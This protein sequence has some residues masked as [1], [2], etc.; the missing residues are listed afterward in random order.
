[1]GLALNEQMPEVIC[2]DDVVRE[3]FLHLL[4]AKVVEPDCAELLGFLI[5]DVSSIS[6]N[7]S[8]RQGLKPL[9]F[10]VVD[11]STSL[12]TILYCSFT[13]HWP[14]LSFYTSLDPHQLSSLK[15]SKG[16]MRC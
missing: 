14:F 7:W 3:S 15:P 11:Y 12:F 9:G 1:M 4:N 5:G 10:W 16:M 13:I 8:Y 2:V 6:I